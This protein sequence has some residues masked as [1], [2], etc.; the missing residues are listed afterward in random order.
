MRK[1]IKYMLGLALTLATI[2]A[3]FI[4]AKAAVSNTLLN[5]NEGR[6]IQI[7][8]PN[9]KGDLKIYKGN[10]AQAIYNQIEREA[11]KEEVL[12][13]ISEPSHSGI[14]PRGMF[15]YK[16]RF[17]KTASG[18]TWGD[19]RRISAY[20][21][22][23]TSTKQSKQIT[24]STSVT[25][26]INLSLTGKYKE[27]F[28]ATVGGNWKYN[29]SFSEVLTINVPPKKRVWLEFKPKLRYIKGEA[30][31]YFK[32][33]GGKPKI[34]IQDRQKVSSTSPVT[35]KMNLGGKNIYCPDGVYVWKEDGNYKNR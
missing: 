31:K 32:T 18:T 34:I 30:Q 4:P 1:S 23:E 22:N 7:A 12:N 8:I 14:A 2:T 6:V 20:A 16:Y 15:T 13:E 19:T 24:A 3:S 5:N 11:K 35:V 21:A 28:D 27:V 9:E 29:S 10:V 33:R 26:G 25:W 17:V